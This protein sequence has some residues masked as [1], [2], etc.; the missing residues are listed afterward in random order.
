[1]DLTQTDEETFLRTYPPVTPTTSSAATAFVETA[2][3]VRVGHCA[4]RIQCIRC[5]VERWHAA[6]LNVG[7]LTVPSHSLLEGSQLIKT[8]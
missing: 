1:M 7:H 6:C 5:A 2:L 4:S 3:Q 8:S